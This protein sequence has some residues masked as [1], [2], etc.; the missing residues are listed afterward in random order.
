MYQYWFT[1]DKECDAQTQD[2]NKRGNCGSG[3]GYGSSAF[4]AK[5]IRSS[6]LSFQLPKCQIK[7]FEWLKLSY[8]CR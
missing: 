1:S 5:V 4:A 7:W 2:V 8:Q 6:V 3:E